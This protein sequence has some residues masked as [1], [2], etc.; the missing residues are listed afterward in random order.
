MAFIKRTEDTI[1]GIGNGKIN[2]LVSVIV[3]TKIPIS[4]RLYF[5]FQTNR[6]QKLR[7][8][9]HPANDNI[10]QSDDPHY[11]IEFLLIY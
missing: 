7:N 8:E 6:Y 4:L 10:Q 11:L 9:A 5:S 2:F 3:K 1:N